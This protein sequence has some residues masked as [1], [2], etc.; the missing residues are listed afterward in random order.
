M[1]LKARWVVVDVWGVQRV[2]AG[3][4]CW[5]VRAARWPLEMTLFHIA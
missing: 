1:A 3:V 5:A 4:M 2:G